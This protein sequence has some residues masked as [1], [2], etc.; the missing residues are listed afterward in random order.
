MIED[1]SR[2]VPTAQI[3]RPTKPVTG[4]PQAAM[5]SIEKPAMFTAR[6]AAVASPHANVCPSSSHGTAAGARTSRTDRRVDRRRR[7]TTLIRAANAPD[8]AGDDGEQRP[9]AAEGQQPGEV[10]G[11]H[12]RGAGEGRRH[13]EAALVERGEG[14]LAGRAPLPPGRR[15]GG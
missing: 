1:D 4:L 8:D 15:T 13:E 6:L 12:G 5:T 14:P 7:R 11:T 9:Q 3:G 2:T 10:E